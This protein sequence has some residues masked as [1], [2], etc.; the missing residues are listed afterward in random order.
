M[1]ATL[2]WLYF[3]PEY[4]NLLGPYRIFAEVYV[5]MYNIRAGSIEEQMVIFVFVFLSPA[6]NNLI[7]TFITPALRP[8]FQISLQLYYTGIV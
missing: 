6:Q 5:H 1:H 4:K 8:I 2:I 3:T 7:I